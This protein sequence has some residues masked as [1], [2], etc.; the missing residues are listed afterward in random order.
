LAISTAALMVGQAF[1]S[2]DPQSSL[3]DVFVLDVFVFDTKIFSDRVA[4]I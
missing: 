1:S 3:F 4:E 2:F